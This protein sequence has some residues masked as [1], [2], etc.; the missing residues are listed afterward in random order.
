[1]L[2]KGSRIWRFP[3]SKVQT[4]CA[5]SGIVLY[6]A[7][8]LVFSPGGQAVSEGGGLKRAE[9]GQGETT[10]DILVSGLDRENG[11]RKIPL[12]ILSGS[13][14]MGRKKQGSCFRGS[15]LN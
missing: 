3:F 8:K 1:M 7:M 5:V 12:K 6:V 14:S 2:R 11:D 4:A 15:S 9:P 13:G 10:Y